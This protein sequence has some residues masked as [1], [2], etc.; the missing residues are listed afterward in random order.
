MTD[1]VQFIVAVVLLLAT[2][3]PTNTVM[4]TGGAVN[5][6]EP[7]WSF[8]LAELGGYLAIVFTSRLVLLPL[9][10]VHPG[11]GVVLKCRRGRL[12]CLGRPSSC[13]GHG[14]AADPTAGRIS[15]RM[16]FVTTFLNPKGLVFAVAVIP[17]NSPALP[18]LLPRVR[19]AA[20]LSS[21][22]A[23]SLPDGRSGVLSG[24]HAARTAAA[25]RCS[26]DR[27]CRLSRRDRRRLSPCPDQSQEL[28][29]AEGPGGGLLVLAV[30]LSTVF[31]REGAQLRVCAPS[32]PWRRPGRAGRAR[33]APD[34]GAASR[35]AADRRD[36]AGSARARGISC[37]QRASRSLVSGWMRL[38]RTSRQNGVSSRSVT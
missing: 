30:R 3:G 5:R 34:S 13:G 24:S 4:A 28:G 31:A 23:G 35:C 14:S 22:F 1:P 26:A 9:I 10:D 6:G 12:S 27:L 36:T 25:R 8:M 2:P 21:G 37:R 33:R 38:A 16:V 29:M 32:R 18:C 15:A 20:C 11:A 7:P 19:R 17:R